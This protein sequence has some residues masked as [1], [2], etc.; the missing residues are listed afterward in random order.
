MTGTLSSNPITILP[1]WPGTVDVGK[2]GISS[3]G[4]ISFS[5][6]KSASPPKVKC[7]LYQGRVATRNDRITQP[8]AAYDPDTRAMLATIEKVAR[9]LFDDLVSISNQYSQKIWLISIRYKH[10]STTVWRLWERRVV[11]RR[12]W[13]LRYRFARKD[14]FEYFTTSTGSLSNERSSWSW[15]ADR[16][17]RNQMP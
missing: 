6:S 4:K 7:N 5:V 17:V 15:Q 3:Y 16:K 9:A 8:R 12:N 2:F 11:G 14:Y 13:D 1:A 10:G